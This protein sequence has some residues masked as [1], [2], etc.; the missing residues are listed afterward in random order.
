MMSISMPDEVGFMCCRSQ[1]VRPAPL[2]PIIA[3]SCCT[4]LSAQDVRANLSM[5][6]SLICS[7]PHMRHG[8]VDPSQLV[9]ASCS[10]AC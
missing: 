3:D 2:E 9:P 10:L 4:F 1:G 7:Q 6:N 8:W 5:L